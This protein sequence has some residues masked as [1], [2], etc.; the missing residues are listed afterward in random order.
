MDLAQRLSRPLRDIVVRAERASSARRQAPAVQV[1]DVEPCDSNIGSVSTSGTLSDVNFTGTLAVSFNGCLIDGVTLNGT[2]MLR[3]DHFEFAMQRPTDFTLS[4]SRLTLRGSGLSI[5]AG[6]SLRWLLT[7]TGCCG[8]GVTFER[9][10]ITANIVS[11]DKSTGKTTKTEPLAIMNEERLT[12]TSTSLTMIVS[13]RVFD[14]DHGY[15]DITTP[16]PLFFDTVTQLFPNSGQML[17][18]GTGNRS[19]RVTA[20]SAT[21]ATLAL[22]LDGN[23]V[24]ENT[25]TVK[26]T[27]LTG[28]V[29][30]DLG[31]ADG[32]GM[33]NS[34]ETVN[35]LNPG[36]DDAAGDKDGD[37]ITNI[38]EYLAGTNP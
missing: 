4:F 8:V 31:D 28:P 38:N 20:L 9:Y 6:G 14:P 17:L 12:S 30:A 22:D 29:G 33:H 3:V 35:G 11:Q 25:A 2:A 32:D 37:L 1:N 36:L 16:T 18:T 10:T 15:V 34:W 13:G 5:D 21:L 23:G 19:V 7:G 24:P 26:W 27:D